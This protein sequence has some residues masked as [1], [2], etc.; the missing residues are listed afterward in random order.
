M[1]GQILRELPDTQV[2]AAAA[3]RRRAAPRATRSSRSGP[4]EGLDGTRVQTRSAA[5]SA[6]EDLRRRRG[7]D[8]VIHCAASRLLRAAARRGARAQRQGPD[9]PA[10]V[11]PRGRQRPVLHPRLDRLR[12]R[13][14]APGSC[15]RSRRAPRRPSRGWTS[16]PSSTP[17]RP[18]AATS[19]PSRACREHQHRFVA[20]AQRAI[21]PAGGPAVGTRAEILRYEWVRDQLIE[22]GRERARALGWSDT[23]G[24][25][26]G[27][28]RAHAARP[29]TRASS[30]S[31]ARRSSSPRSTRRTRAGWSR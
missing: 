30:R 18:G 16:T 31:S 20:E 22:R 15:S 14:C 29:R 19:R 5:T 8:I 4:C 21:G 9:P 24:A 6:D 25:L 1:L 10:A 12:R 27:D 28:R 3:R 26:E 23:Y 2:I 7:I 17:P 13:A 11:R